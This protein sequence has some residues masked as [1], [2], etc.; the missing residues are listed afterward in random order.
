MKIETYIIKVLET[1]C[2][3]NFQTYEQVKMSEVT[4]DKVL[5][6]NEEQG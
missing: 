5:Y 2:S 3:C 6:V 4:L 1:E